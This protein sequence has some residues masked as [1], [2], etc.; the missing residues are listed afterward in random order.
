LFVPVSSG[1]EDGS[2]VHA[3]ETERSGTKSEQTRW[4]SV[5]ELAVHF[6][7]NPDTVYTWI[8]KKEMPPTGWAGSRKMKRS[9]VDAWARCGRVAAKLQSAKI[10][11]AAQRDEG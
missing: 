11:K 7:V 2:C 5:D 9:E 3:T 8:G 10:G 6:G 4:L 1:I